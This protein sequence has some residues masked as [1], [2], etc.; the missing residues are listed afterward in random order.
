M[1][2][3][4]LIHPEAIRAPMPAFATAAPPYPPSNAW[5]EDDG[6]PSHQV[7]KFQTIAP[8]RPAST[9]FGSQPPDR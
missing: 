7:T 2:K 6:N 9:T 3:I 5:D 4:G 1:N 8:R